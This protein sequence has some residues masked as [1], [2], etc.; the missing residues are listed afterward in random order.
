VSKD[1]VNVIRQSVK[2]PVTSDLAAAKLGLGAVP[3]GWESW[4]ASL[5]AYFEKKQSRKDILLEF[6][7]DKIGE[8]REKLGLPPEDDYTSCARAEAAEGELRDLIELRQSLRKPQTPAAPRVD[9]RYSGMARLLDDRDEK[10]ILRSIGKPDLAV[11]FRR[12]RREIYFLYVYQFKSEARSLEAKRIEFRSVPLLNIHLLHLKLLGCVCG[13]LGAG[14]LHFL[15]V[16][17]AGGISEYYVNKALGL[18]CVPC[19]PETA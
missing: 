3:Q 11:R 7:G 2:L 10:F 4:Y 12:Q 13:M 8:T 16:Q 17:R 1:K 5:V 6:I 18:I 15:R 9:Q 14:I 19:V